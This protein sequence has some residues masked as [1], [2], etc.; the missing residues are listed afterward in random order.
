[1]IIKELILNNYGLFS[2]ECKFDVA[3]R[4]KYGRV[5]P[6]VLFGGKNGAGKTTFLES[7]KLLL[8]GRRAIG[9]RISQREYEEALLAR[10]HRNKNENTRAPYAK[11]GLT[12][13][14][15]TAGVKHEYFV[16]RS[17]MVKRGNKIDE[18]FRVERDKKPL[19]DISSL[20]WESFISDI[21]PERLAQLFFFDGEKIKSIAEDISSNAAIAEAIQSLLGLD[22]VQS[23]KSDLMIYRT[24][25]LK[26]ADPE[27]YG[28]ELDDIQTKIANAQQEAGVIAHELAE[29]GSQID[30]VVC[31]I[32]SIELRL[33]E[34]GGTFADRRTANKH[35][36]EILH[37]R[38]RERE[39]AIRD[40]SEGILPLALCPSIV[41]T[42]LGQLRQEEIARETQSA[43]R[44]VDAVGSYLRNA[45]KQPEVRA[46]LE[47]HLS[48]YRDKLG[49]IADKPSIHGLSARDVMQLEQALTVRLTEERRNVQEHLVK[50]EADTTA[51]HEIEKDLDRAPDEADLQ[52]LLAALAERNRELGGL[53]E[54]QVQLKERKARLDQQLAGL[55]RDKDKLDIK[56]KLG[57][58]ENEKLERL[59]K[60]GPA[61]D[62]YRD[63]LTRAKIAVLESEVSACFNKLARKSD[64]VKAI[65][66]NATTFAV[67]VLDQQGREVPKEDLSSGEKQIFAIAMLWGLARTSGRPLPVVVDTPLGRLDSDHR[68][69]LIHNYFPHAGHQVILL[70]TDT[71]V[72]QGLFRELSPAVSHC[73]HLTYDEQEGRTFHTEEYFW[74][75]RATA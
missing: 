2:G 5:R 20:H 12:F 30:G 54:K 55:S 22:A 19:D 59:T 51:L 45:T 6:V 36:T 57:D 15:V 61:L 8:Y 37:R 26:Q 11:I 58:A 7:L 70:S 28:R 69:N 56:K 9:E 65:R 27:A 64:F 60:L 17:W 32:S 75:E 53:N 73:W 50:L 35:E 23:L 71:E 25:L 72:D 66:I 44:Q 16:E 47:Q 13:D 43:V 14:H 31:S 46:F 49:A 62:L 42:L 68:A 74:R 21:V 41:T 29:V 52:E 3:P 1:M 39:Q 18:F 24:R 33:A 67:S 38:I 48:A 34:K 63:R 10:V 4:S 40:A